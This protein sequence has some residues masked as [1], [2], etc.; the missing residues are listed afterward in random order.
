[1]NGFLSAPWIRTVL[2]RADD[3]RAEV[4]L[5]CAV[6]RGAT[7]GAA[8]VLVASGTLTGPECSTAATL[9][10][11][12]VLV[13]QGWV[14]G[15]PALARGVCTEPGF[16]TPE[17]PNLYRAEVTLRRGDEVVAAGRR[18]VGLRRLG[19]KE[20]S[21]W[22]DGR[23]YVPRGVPHRPDPAGLAALRELSAVAVID[24]VPWEGDVSSIDVLAKL[25][26]TLTS[27]DRDGVA[28]V[29]RLAASSGARVDPG[30][31]AERIAAWGAHPSV[32][33]VILP[34]S[35]PPADVGG[36]R[37][38][39][40]RG[41]L[42]VGREVDGLEPPP[43]SADGLDAWV[44]MLPPDGV[45]HEAWQHPPKLP[46]VAAITAPA[47]SHPAAARAECDRL[48]ARL[49]AWGSHEAG[50]AW[51]WAGYLVT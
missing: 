39:Q 18:M 1:M 33:L 36:S 7:T 50:R 6:E 23:R 5:R 48:Q 28:V 38:S 10:T 24:D 27:A 40:R 3:M 47:P 51:D 13:D 46:L 30:E 31:I 22:L 11:T 19:V 49:A 37:V 2:G 9:P 14:E 17:L 25:D 16:W 45:P 12:V 4:W 43:V 32:F 44:V 21:F 34:R 8:P 35:I 42:L 41:T 26:D 15:Q 20:R 29:L